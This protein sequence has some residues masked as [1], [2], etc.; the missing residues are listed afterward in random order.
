MQI[1]TI[2]GNHFYTQQISKNLQ[3]RLSNV[4]QD[5]EQEFYTTRL[6]LQMCKTTSENNVELSDM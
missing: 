3:V 2:S 4:G 1:K 5:V 6:D